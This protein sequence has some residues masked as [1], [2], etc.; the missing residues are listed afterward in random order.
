MNTQC[1]VDVELNDYYC[2]QEAI[3]DAI[4]DEPI[5]VRLFETKG[6][7]LEEMLMESMMDQRD[8]PSKLLEALKHSDKWLAGSILLQALEEYTTQ[9]EGYWYD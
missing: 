1:R 9:T 3:E 6:V 2:R 4:D 7:N 8:T 5:L